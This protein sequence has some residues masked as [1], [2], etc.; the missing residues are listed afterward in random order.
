MGLA[1]AVLS[2]AQLVER[3][4]V[5]V[6]RKLWMQ[7][8]LARARF[9]GL[10]RALQEI[11][12]GMGA[13]GVNPIVCKGV[14]LAR[15]YYPE[16]GERYMND[17]DLWVDVSEEPSC[18][19]V[20]EELG[21]AR[22]SFARDLKEAPF[23]SRQGMLVDLHTRMELFE[24]QSGGVRA[25][26][27]PLPGTTLRVFEPHALLAH[28]CAH[29]G[30]HERDT[31]P[32]LCWFFDVAYVLRK[33][34]DTLDLRQLRSRMPS[35]ACYQAFLRIVATLKDSFGFTPPEALAQVAHGVPSYPLQTLLRLRRIA[36]FGTGH[37]RGWA[38]LAVTVLGLRDPKGR[39]RP[40]WSELACWS[41][42]R[43]AW[44]TARFWRSVA[45]E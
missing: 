17:I 43:R 34:G 15:D 27:R 16:A 19:A 38:T 36:L 6:R 41:R 25:T 10:W 44:G 24:G 29:L 33:H 11:A 35:D 31:G 18:L 5:G 30:G 28:L 21:Y 1:F 4:P 3:I 42:D 8:E 40:R 22:R 32:M 45:G 9:E 39:V 23:Q 14:L 2:R 20:L 26:T 7:F 13:R 12:R 37:A